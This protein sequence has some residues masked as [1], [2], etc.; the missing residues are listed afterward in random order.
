[1]SYIDKH[2][3]IKCY[4]LLL[5]M[6]VACGD[7]IKDK[8]TAEEWQAIY[9]FSERQSLLGVMF[10]VVEKLPKALRPD[11]NLLF[12]WYGDCYQIECQNRFLNEKAVQTAEYYEKRG[13]KNCILKGQGNAL[14]YPN[15]L[16]R[17][18]GDIDIWCWPMKGLINF[19]RRHNSKGK[20]TYHHID[21]GIVDD[22]EIEVH[23]RPSFLNS[24]IHNHRL[25]KWFEEHRNEQ[26]SHRVELSE[27]AGSICIPTPAFNR[28]FLIAHIYN[29]VIHEGIGLRQLMDYYYV[30]KQ[31]F[32][33]EERKR[34]ARLL[35]RF[36]LYQA[37]GA[38]MYVLRDVFALE[39]QYYIVPADERRGKFLLDE[40]MQGGNFGWY[41]PRVSHN[42]GAIGKNL[43]RLKRD[44]RLVRF[45]P[46]GCLWEPVFRVWHF[47]WRLFH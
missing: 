29:H 12:A 41:D 1:M 10:S 2:E 15:P 47:F 18:P 26:F 13:Y 42:Q 19:V 32:T 39:E 5:R 11:E 34:D 45:F 4:G 40:I 30:L 22:V 37:A 27:G 23:Y 8:L 20:A 21:A 7:S 44:F 17:T 28:I 9:N 38:V 25:Q 33:E 14:M 6:S 16:R 36:G 46:S 3:L 24:F 31:G 43:Q 35:K